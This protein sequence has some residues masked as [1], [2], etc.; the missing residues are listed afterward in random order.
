MT[1]PRDR[2]PEQI[3]GYRVDGVHLLQVLTEALKDKILD[4]GGPD[5]GPTAPF[6]TETEFY[7]TCWSPELIDRVTLLYGLTIKSRVV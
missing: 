4:L 6:L 7:S 5:I 3:N 2:G 1:S